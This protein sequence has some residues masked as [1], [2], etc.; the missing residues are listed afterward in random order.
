[1]EFNQSPNQELNANA[2]P[3]ASG[4][5]APAQPSAKN[6]KLNKRVILII[7]AG[8]AV[9][10]LALPAI[11]LLKSSHNSTTSSDTVPAASVSIT[12]QGFTPVTL[13]VKKGTKVTWTNNGN[14]P[15]QVASNPHPDH[16]ELKGLDSKGPIGPE[17]TYSYTFDKPGEY[18]YHDHF[19]PTVSGTV[20]VE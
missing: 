9:L 7:V 8:L 2:T 13:T 6:S 11:I 14:K 3:P 12:D 15:R 19:N 5:E 16:T 18:N 17:S 4:G 20:V 10:G 1:M